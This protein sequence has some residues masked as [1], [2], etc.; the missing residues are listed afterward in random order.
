MLTVI[1][2][3]LISFLYLLNLLNRLDAQ[4]KPTIFLEGSE[5]L[6]KKLTKICWQENYFDYAN[7]LKRMKHVLFRGKNKAQIYPE[8]YN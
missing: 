2:W 5:F 1:F 4:E 7:F 3:S 6:N 8:N